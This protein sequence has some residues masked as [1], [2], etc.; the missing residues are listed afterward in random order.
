M[1]VGKQGLTAADLDWLPNPNL[2][3]NIALHMLP[4]PFFCTS[5]R[6]RMTSMCDIPNGQAPRL[7]QA[8]P[9]QPRVQKV[10]VNI[11]AS[12]ETCGAQ[13]HVKRAGHSL[14]QV[15]ALSAE[16]LHDTGWTGT[17]DSTCPA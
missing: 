2:L 10:S 7:L 16:A 14:S 3:A 11:T 9:R 1:L 12:D 15:C 13:P 6:L 4:F 8:Q 5:D 17:V